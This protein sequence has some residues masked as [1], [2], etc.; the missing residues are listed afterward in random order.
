MPLA[1]QMCFNHWTTREVHISCV[2]VCVCVCIYVCV[3]VCVCV[4]WPH[5]QLVGGLWN[6]G[7]LTRD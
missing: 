7:S 3:C 6:L 5:I 2:C 1:L 4:F